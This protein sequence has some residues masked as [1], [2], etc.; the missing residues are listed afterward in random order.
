VK[1]LLV[2]HAA[3][4]DR[5][6][7]AASGKP[8]DE[9][10]L[11]REGKERMRRLALTAAL[12]VPEMDLVATSPLK[13]STQTARLLAGVWAD[14]EIATLDSLAP[15]IPP[16]DTIAWLAKHAN[17]RCAALVGHEPSLGELLS[18]MLGANSPIHEF[19]KG[20]MALVSFSAKPAA[21]GGLLEWVLPPSVARLVRK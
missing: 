2:R 4:E 13:R 11:T 14:M 10:P 5:G 7:F 16:G 3:A 15:G 21:G 19:R 9:R 6:E 1:V 17:L 20:G 12:L 18:K 8:D